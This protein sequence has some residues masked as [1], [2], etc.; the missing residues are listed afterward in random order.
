MR[1]LLS[2]LLIACA[3]F[4]FAFSAGIFAAESG[5]SYGN[6]PQTSVPIAIDGK[7]DA[8]YDKGL[9]VKNI[10]ILHTDSQKNTGCVGTAYVVWN[11]TDTMYVFCS[12][13][14]PKVI[15]YEGNP[16]PWSVDSVEL[17]IDF[18]NKV[19]RTRDQYRIDVKNVATYYDTT[20]YYGDDCKKYGFSNWG[21]SST[22]DGY[23]VEFEIKAYKEPIAADM[24]IGFHIM[25]NECYTGGQSNLH[26]D[27]CKNQPDSFGYI[28]LTS[29]KVTGI[30]IETTAAAAA[31][32]DA[33]K[34]VAAAQTNDIL[35]YAIAALTVSSISITAIRSR[36]R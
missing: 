1:K 22:S 35:I 13:K 3:L 21:M 34:P 2:V 23:D 17:F 36:K 30:V 15:I 20:T 18:S 16:D 26:S 7:K 10:N 4:S 19:A 8:V 27:K 29:E 25:I 11:G 14:D 32:T 28:T 12:V 24:K 6:V 9:V 5:T 33:A 31:A